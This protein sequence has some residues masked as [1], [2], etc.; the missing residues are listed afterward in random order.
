LGY[1]SG[2]R[3]NLPFILMVA[4]LALAGCNRGDEK[5]DGYVEGE[6]VRVAPTTGGVLSELNVERGT[7]VK[8]GQPLFALDLTT[9]TADRD[10]AKADL[11]QAKAKFSDL[12]KGKRPEEIAVIEEQRAQAQAVLENAE[13]QWKRSQSLS[14]KDATSIKERDADKS[15]YDLAVAQV[16]ELENQLKVAGL[17]GRVDELDAAQAS[18]DTAAQRLA[19]AE[20]RLSEAAPKAPADAMVED[21]FYR[22]GEFVT[23]GSP[24]VSLLSPEN[25]KVRFFVPEKHFAEFRLGEPVVIHCDGCTAPVAGKITFLSNKAEFTPPVIYSIESRDKLVFMIEARPDK[26]EPG[27][28]P[29]LP[30]DVEPSAP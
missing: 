29:G 27:L 20:K 24:V 26:F 18:V 4:L 22:A 1:T 11:S 3:Q 10:A 8:A 9:L 5:L 17:S 14:A 23:A 25:I 13:A 6:F 15:A 7:E 30:V 21:T 28:K 19:Q 2:M 16:K 12:T